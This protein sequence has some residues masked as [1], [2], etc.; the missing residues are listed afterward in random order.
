[1][2]DW[3]RWRV[4]LGILLWWLLEVLL[5]T[6]YARWLAWHLWLLR[7]LLPGILKCSEGLRWLLLLIWRWLLHLLLRGKVLLLPKHRRR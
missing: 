6:W 5:L 4:R 1:M 7:L 3:L 2:S